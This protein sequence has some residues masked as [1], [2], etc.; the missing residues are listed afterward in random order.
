MTASIFLQKVARVAVRKGEAAVGR[1]YPLKPTLETMAVRPF[2]LHFELTNLCNANCVFCPYQFQERPIETMSDEV[3]EKA[4]SDYTA[5]FGG[6]V[7]FTPIVGDAL[8]DKKFLERVRAARACREVDRIKVITNAILVDRFGADEIINSGLTTLTIS[9]AGFDEAMYRRVYRSKQYK[10][11]RRN[12]LDLLKANRAAGDPVNIVIGLRPDRPLNEVTAHP[13]F[14]EVLEYKPYLDFTWSYTTA[15]GRITREILPDQMR[16]RQA[17]RKTEPC[18]ETYN[19]PIVLPDGTVLICS[20]VAAIDGVEDLGIGNVLEQSLGDIWRSDRVRGLRDS[21][22]T[23]CL[24]PTCAGCDMY[25]NLELY[26]TREGR[27]RAKIN[28]LRSQGVIVK[29]GREVGWS[30]G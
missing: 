20:C 15:N 5:D 22:G 29:R 26:R 3:F 30:G 2:E 16:I 21:F 18:V 23:S 10:R 28:R 19:G 17:P 25:R 1:L 11:V 4:L 24:N 6:S 8:I 7:F 13:D 27:E 14:Q 12:V 9:I